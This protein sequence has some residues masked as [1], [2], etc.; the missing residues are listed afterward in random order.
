MFLFFVP[1]NLVIF[2]DLNKFL[3][4]FAFVLMNNLYYICF[5]Y[6]VTFAFAM[7]IFGYFYD[8]KNV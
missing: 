6:F 2:F 7:F 4:F 8:V 5:F 1:S 3:A